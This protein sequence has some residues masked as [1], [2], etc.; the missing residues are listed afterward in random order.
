MHERCLRLIY[1]DKKPSYEN[2]LEK[3]NSV[4]IEHKNIQVLVVE[5]FKVKHK[6]CP[7]I[8]SDVFMEW[9]NKQ[10]NL[11]NRPDFTTPQVLLNYLIF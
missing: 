2:L 6:L 10:Y 9:T 7:E 1:S 5:I 8:T 11:H 3:D 4:S